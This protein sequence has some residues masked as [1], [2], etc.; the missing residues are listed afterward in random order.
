MAMAIQAH[1]KEG[2]LA[3]ERTDNRETVRLERAMAETLFSLGPRA[4]LVSAFAG[5]VLVV[6]LW[7]VGSP[8]W[9]IAWYLALLASSLWR[10]MIIVRGQRKD[11]ISTS[12]IK[13]YRAGVLA[14]GV[15]W[16]SA[17]FLV[18]PGF[19]LAPV[20]MIAMVLSGMT[21]GAVTVLSSV[22][23]TLV[24][25]AIPAL[26]P[27]ATILLTRV[28]VTAT[29]AGLLVLL[30][31]F[32]VRR[33]ER[34][35]HE[36]LRAN[37]ELTMRVRT[38][39]DRANTT[40]E[41]LGEGVLRVA[42]DGTVRYLNPAAMRIVGT[43]ISALG[44]SLEDI[45][46][47][48]DETDQNSITYKLVDAG[49]RGR[50]VDIEGKLIGPEP[51]DSE[52]WVRALARPLRSHSAGDELQTVVVLQDISQ[53]QALIGELSHIATH[54]SLTGLQNRR[55][56]QDALTEVI[57][58][59]EGGDQA[60][61]HLI[62]IDLDGFKAV[63][64]TVG[65][66]AGDRVLRDVAQAMRSVVGKSALLARLGGDE[67]GIVVKGRGDEQVAELVDRLR[68][69]VRAV[70]VRKEEAPLSVGASA[71]VAR[72]HGND[73]PEAVLARA[74]EECY[75]VKALRRAR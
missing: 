13:E 1:E 59:A 51:D 75:R 23:N 58:S 31:L 47:I 45:M 34:D 36:I 46:P 5:L 40:L 4:Q 2:A 65:H 19:P 21:A 43:G 18:A 20:A 16:G 71:G 12:L 66:L 28:D 38:Q 9:L 44:R 17:V 55:A 62:F 57:G 30:A 60:A 14:S 48:R 15:V 56:L 70:S 49:T 35:L 27:I 32:S 24:L 53:A 67:F 61:G 74:D 52:R 41:S 37:T 33:I 64:D 10:A 7:P 69:A 42:C 39:R 50:D 6:G 73:S 8:T 26:V 63:N 22:R 72:I 11:A 68:A 29:A 25:F 3:R 54:D